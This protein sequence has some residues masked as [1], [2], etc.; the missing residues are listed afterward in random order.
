MTP[1]ALIGLIQHKTGT[2]APNR[3]WNTFVNRMYYTLGNNGRVIRT[4]K[5]GVQTQRAWSTL[6]AD[7]RDKIAKKILPAEYHAEYNALPAGNKFDALRAM[8]NMNRKA[9]A[10]AATKAKA[11]AAEKAKAAA[12]K[13]KK[14]AEEAAKENA[15]ANAFALE[16]EYG[17][18]LA[19]NLG[20]LYK[21]GNEQAFLA[22]Y[23][24]LPSGSRGKPLKVNVEKAYRLFTKNLKAQRS[25]AAVKNAF[26]AAISV[27]NWLPASK[28]NAYKTLV[29][30]LALQ[31]P[32]PKVANFKAAIKAWLNREVPQSPARAARQVENL[33]TGEKRIIPAYVPKKRPSPVLPKLPTATAKKSPKEPKQRYPVYSP[34]SLNFIS[35]TMNR[36]KLNARRQKG[37]T[38]QEF[39]SAV[40]KKNKSVNENALKA[41]WNAE[42]VK[43]A[44]ATGATGRVKR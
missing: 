19:Q 27:P 16:L 25:D 12:N 6:D 24:K 9:K 33:I 28:A 15:E 38:V 44:R 37:W 1:G 3:S 13:A 11:N 7:T 36:Y 31:K 40:K 39:I 2:Y 30:N 29:A 4:T 23:R 22:E 18:R 43:K 20:N 5:E 21:T 17:M 10:N 14:N 34:M 32:K 42:V 8:V 35:N 26:K 41:M